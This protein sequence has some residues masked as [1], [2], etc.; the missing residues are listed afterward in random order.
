MILILILSIR[1]TYHFSK[2]EAKEEVHVDSTVHDRLDIHMD[3]TFPSITCSTIAL[4]AVD[5]T[6][7]SQS[8]S[9]P[10]IFKLP[11]DI[12][13][14]ANGPALHQTTQDDTILTHN[15]L[16]HVL[17]N[18]DL[19]K[20]TPK[21]PL[22]TKCGTCYSDA[23]DACCDSCDQVRQHFLIRGWPFHIDRFWQCNGGIHPLSSETGC[24]IFGKIEVNKAK[25]SFHFAP[26]L[27]TTDAF[28]LFFGIG[29]TGKYNISHT[30]HKLWFGD[31]APNEA[32]MVMSR[33]DSRKDLY[34]PLPLSN[35]RV[36]IEN[37]SIVQYYVKVISTRV[38]L[39]NGTTITF[40][41]YSANE[42]VRETTRG[43]LPSLH[44]FY[45]T[46]PL[47]LRFQENEK[48][49]G[50]L[51]TNICALIGG[52]ITLVGFVDNILHRNKVK[53]F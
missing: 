22:N 32:T 49:W 36:V 31:V 47:L 53:L 20:E 18:S 46:P 43:S 17:K 38:D 41:Q 27:K 26:T 9:L 4:K 29:S 52:T 6:G 44:L 11:L 1:E 12:N 48:P 15:Q 51:L 50:H 33:I 21:A 25:G 5:A 45:D 7:E 24:Q 3:I 42:H 34:P 8:E 10:Y 13:S 40:T 2:K 35:R 16:Q 14:V 39:L 23:I 37:D 30:I 28:A 19:P